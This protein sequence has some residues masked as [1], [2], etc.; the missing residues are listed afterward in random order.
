MNSKLISLIEG[1][2]PMIASALLPRAISGPAKMLADVAISALADGLGLPHPASEDE[3][4]S[5]LLGVTPTVR[6]AVLVRADAN[7]QNT[8]APVTSPSFPETTTT[9][10]TTTVPVDTHTGV[11]SDLPS[12]IVYML[13][14]AVGGSLA[15]RGVDLGNI[16]QSITGSPDLHV[17]ASIIA[18]ALMLLYRSVSGTNQNTLAMAS[19]EK[20]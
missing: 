2:A 6:D 16:F 17:G 18:G 5:Q 15:S 12:M 3:I 9:T 10:T 13:L 11:T 19:S 14:M 1:A 7:F 20:L 8:L 4:V